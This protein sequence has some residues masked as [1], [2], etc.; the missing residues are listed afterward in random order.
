MPENKLKMRQQ[1]GGDEAMVS[2]L[3]PAHAERMSRRQMWILKR[4]LRRIQEG[5]R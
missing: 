5:R 2:H 1:W 3:G 4:N